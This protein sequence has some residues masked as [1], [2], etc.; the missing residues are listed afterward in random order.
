MKGMAIGKEQSRRRSVTRWVPLAGLLSWLS[1]TGACEDGG[2]SRGEDTSNATGLAGS[3]EYLSSGQLQDSAT[4]HATQHTTRIRSNNAHSSK[5]PWEVVTATYASSPGTAL[6]TSHW[7]LSADPNPLGSY[8]DATLTLVPGSEEE[9]EILAHEPI[10][11]L[12]CFYR[13]MYC[14]ELVVSLATM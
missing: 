9:L 12:V 7:T 6:D 4:L 13:N 3:Q 2:A 10:V 11:L 14:E 5:L 1:V 8:R